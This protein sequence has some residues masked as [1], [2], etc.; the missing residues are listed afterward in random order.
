MSQKNVE[1]VRRIFEATVT[2]DAAAVLARN[3]PDVELDFAR[4]PL[5]RLVGADVYR[6]H[7]GVRRWARDRYEVW[8]WVEDP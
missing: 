6:G 8:D 7:D 5:T 1:I 3:D 2:R 4:A